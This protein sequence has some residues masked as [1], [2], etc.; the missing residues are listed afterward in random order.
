MGAGKVPGKTR[1]TKISGFFFTRGGGGGD[2]GHT[3]ILL[4]IAV[5]WSKER[6]IPSN[7]RGDWDVDKKGPKGRVG[8]ERQKGKE[9]L[10]RWGVK[11]VDHPLRGG[12]GTKKGCRKWEV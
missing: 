3:M 11:E 2:N 6:K 10:L 5:K 1:A 8:G 4:C 12:K 7:T 9:S